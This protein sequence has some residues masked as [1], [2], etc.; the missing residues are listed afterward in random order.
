VKSIGLSEI[1]VG[2]ILIP[3]VGNA[4]EHSSAILMAMKNRMD[5]AVGIA[6]GSSVQVALLVAPLLVFIGL[7]F[8]QPMDL[9]FSMM[10][11]VSVASGCN[12]GISRNQGQRVGLAGG[13]DFF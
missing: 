2:L 7:L 11:V 4:A 3:I 5:L 1:F 13:V 8:G 10:E 9:A 6:V 12:G